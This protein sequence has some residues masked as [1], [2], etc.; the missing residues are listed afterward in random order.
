MM[1]GLEDFIA[2]YGLAV[3]L[4][5]AIVEGETIVVMA[6]FLC[7]QGV[8]EPGS[9]FLAAFLGAWI[10][11]QAL[12][13]LGRHFVEAHFVQRQL[14]R[15]LFAK[16]LVRIEQNPTEFILAFRFF[17]GFRVVS[18]I[19]VGVSSIPTSR[20]V[21]LNTLSAIVWAALMTAIGY[22]LSAVFHVTAGSL[23][24]IEHKIVAAF[25]AAIIV[26]VA[27]VLLTQRLR[28]SA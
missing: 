3:V 26:F 19:A 13:V 21:V 10:G 17:Y 12:F 20:Y 28:R 16:V 11:D 4:I 5:G 27:V 1:A 22:A 15:P 6:G 7:H 23:P 18:P 24:A 25:A 14:K 9:V 8:M 2:A